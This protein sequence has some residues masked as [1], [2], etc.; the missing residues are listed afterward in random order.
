M[1]EGRWVTEA[2]NGYGQTIEIR[3]CLCSRQSRFQKIEVFETVKL[4][5][6]LMLDGIIQLTDSDEFVYHEMLVNLPFYAHSGIPR[7]ALVIGGGDGGALRE[8]A[9]HPELETLD[10][11]EIDG[12]VIA[13][14]KEFLPR[15]ACGYDDPRVAV[16]IADGSE[17]VRE[18]VGEFDLIIVDSTDPGGPGAPLFGEAFYANLKRALRPGGVIAT[19]SESPFL[20]PELVRQLNRAAKKNFR[21]VSYAGFA[22]P[23]Y[24]TGMIGACVASDGRDVRTPD[25]QPSTELAETLRYYNGSVH[26]A[27]FAMPGFVAR[28]LE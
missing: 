22:V 27:S 16:H 9:R 5:R 14:A 20:L 7:R 21:F 24:P 18:H 11:C 25:R 19:Q 12:E 26:T 2:A 4:G 28:L 1:M 3:E 17:F 8:L 13:A 6:M 15:T 10:I 23:T